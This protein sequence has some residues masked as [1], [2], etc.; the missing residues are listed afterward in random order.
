MKSFVK[1]RARVSDRE[2][3]TE[4]RSI[5]FLDDDD[6]TKLIIY[7]ADHP[8]KKHAEGMKWSSQ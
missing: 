4:G 7:R 3:V 5:A 6:R 1:H 8:A 2:N